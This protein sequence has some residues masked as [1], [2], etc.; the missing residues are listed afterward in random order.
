M[1]YLLQKL[2]VLVVGEKL[3]TTVVFITEII[4]FT[5]FT[6]SVMNILTT[7]MVAKDGSTVIRK[8]LHL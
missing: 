1:P 6:L 8:R 7:N 2:L 3:G 5:V 4:V